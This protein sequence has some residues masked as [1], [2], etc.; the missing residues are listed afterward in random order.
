MASPPVVHPASLS[1]DSTFIG[2]FEVREAYASKDAEAPQG[3]NL[4]D[5]SSTNPTANYR[6]GQV[7]WVYQKNNELLMIHA[8]DSSDMLNDHFDLFTLDGSCS[9]EGK[10]SDAQ[11]LGIFNIGV[12]A[13]NGDSDSNSSYSLKGGTIGKGQVAAVAL[14]APFVMVG[15][16]STEIKVM[17]SNSIEV[18]EHEVYRA[19]LVIQGV[20]N[21]SY[22]L[23][24]K[25]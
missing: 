11:K 24:R 8:P 9:K 6:C 21:N 16:T 4:C 25:N 17:D 12:C 7:A 15:P 14:A 22:I 10:I 5:I 1:G 2:K 23:K 20:S 3:G 18:D 13:A 19:L